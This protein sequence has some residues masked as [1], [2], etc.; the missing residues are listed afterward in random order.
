[1]TQR[2]HP[3]SLLLVDDS[4][5][6][7]MFLEK[8]FLDADRDLHVSTIA[9]DRNAVE[10]IVKDDYDLVILDK[11]MPV[12]DGLDVIR[13]VRACKAGDRPKFIMLSSSVRTQDMT[14]AY[15]AG[16]L[17]YLVKPASKAGYRD[18]ALNTL[19]FWTGMSMRTF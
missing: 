2:K 16:V 4:V 18:L 6:D 17:A 12:V 5:V 19:S 15:E 3:R 11:N 13:A 1:M 8:A 7:L 10:R 9:D 14:D